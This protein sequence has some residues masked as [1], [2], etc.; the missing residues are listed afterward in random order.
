MAKKRTD[1]RSELMHE[2]RT[3][4]TRCENW[5]KTARARFVDD[6]K[7]C[8]GD[9]DNGYQWPE[10]IR[11][12][13]DGDRRAMLTINKTKQ[14]CLDIENDARQSKVAIKIRPTGDGS[15]V[16]SAKSFMGVIR[17]IEYISNASTRLPARPRARCAGVRATGG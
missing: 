4:F 11:Q 7:F 10:T 16:D 15:T 13:M 2:V 5:E 1:D 3:R 17:H 6:T 14:H 12:R 8:E 9:S